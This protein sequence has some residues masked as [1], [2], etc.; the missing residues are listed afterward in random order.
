[1]SDSDVKRGAAIAGLCA[2]IV[3]LAVAA[4]L[5]GC[6]VGP[7]YVKPA[8]PVAATFAGAGDAAYGTD[9]AQA[10]FWTQFGDPTLDQL[11]DDA[12]LSNHDL[13]IA[14][15][16]LVEARALRREAQFDLAPTVTAAGGYTKE[17][18]P[19]VDSPTGAPLSTR[20]YDAGFDASWELDLFGRVRRNVEAQS[21]EVQ[22]AAATLRDAQVSVSAEVAR[23]YFELRGQQSELSVARRNVDN[24]K[25][26]LALTQARLDAGSGTE[27]DTSRAQSQLSATL[28]TIGPLEAGI[29]R[30]V[31]RLSVLTG[32][33]P[34]ALDGL[35]QA[36]HELPEL[37]RMTQVGDPAGLL[38]R[39]PDIRIAERQLAASTALV[40]VAIGDL[41]PK[42]TFTGSFNYTAPEVGGL[43][44]S[45][46]R[47][48]VI[49][50]AISWAAFD[51]G[52]VR[53][54]VAGSRARADVALAGYEQ[55]V[56][57]AL[58]ETEDALVTHARTRSS[59]KDATDAAQAS[60]TAAR[61]AR[62]RYEGGLVDFLDVLDAER[63]ELA[64]EDRLAQSRTQAATSLVA[65][66]K[67]LGGGW[68]DAPLP[69]Y[70]R[71]TGS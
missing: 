18:F 69:R 33:D 71:A 50:P 20:F 57:K 21:A 58:E 55:S 30:S 9:E 35:L 31:H 24:Q 59:L 45:S 48:Y 2:V 25:E 34:N 46:S 52:R 39:R 3:L 70:V 5:A 68:Q 43:G 67:A 10:K 62:T 51:L 47:G 56:L 17:R 61:I 14:L 37:P 63:T 11:V 6:A 42:V 40:G 29:A 49:G 65:V 7:N 8:T 53:A 44:E 26:T 23:T 27:L 41:F 60:A 19:Q 38:R 4:A 36:A 12:L 28:A 66:Y 16:H 15:G 54:Q 22:G 1:M 13:R 64:A 32:R